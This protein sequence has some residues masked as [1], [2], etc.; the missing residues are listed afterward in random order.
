VPRR[1]GWEGENSAADIHV[2]PGGRFVYG[3]NRGHDSL[4]IYAVDEGTGQLTYTG[5]VSTGGRTP[6]NFAIDPT[7][8]FVLVANQDTDTIVT[9]G[10]DQS[11]GALT[12]TGGVVSTGTPVCV[13]IT[14]MGRPG[15]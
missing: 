13:K 10:V 5:N 7:G 2:H 3:S 9:F 6:R 4:A 1:A 8:R 15:R 14:P 11:T 12:P